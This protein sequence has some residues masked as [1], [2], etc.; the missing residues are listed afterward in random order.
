[1]TRTGPIIVLGC[2]I[3]A[4]VGFFLPLLSGVF[5]GSISGWD[6]ISEF[7][8]GDFTEPWLIFIGT[9]ILLISAVIAV[10]ALKASPKVVF[11]LSIAASLGAALA[12]GGA[13][14]FLIEAINNDVAEFL[15]YGFYTTFAAAVLGLVFGIITNIT[16]QRAGSQIIE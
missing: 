13:T 1:M 10:A 7:G 16:A 15:S 12:I 6:V 4:L 11:Y 9:I 2:G 5:G 14:L 3:V 8:I